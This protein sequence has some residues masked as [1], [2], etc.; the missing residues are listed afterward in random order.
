[1]RIG[2]LTLVAAL[3]AACT[4]DNDTFTADGQGAAGDGQVACAPGTTRCEG[5][6]LVTCSASGVEVRSKCTGGCQD[7]KCLG[8]VEQ[9]FFLDGDRDGFGNRAQEI[10]ACVAPDGYVTDGGDCDDVDP[11]AHPGQ[12]SFFTRT[13]KGT[14]GFDF[15]CNKIEEKEVAHLVSC[16]LKGGGCVGDGWVQAVPAC[17]QQGT[18]GHC[19]R[20]AGHVSCVQNNAPQV[21]A[22]R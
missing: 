2:I 22:C 4:E 6:V 9:S 18:F 5:D 12:S 14:T 10:G 15:N 3:T 11:A 8:C 7:G 13:T 20:A 1:V 21:Q 16:T 17:G 19:T